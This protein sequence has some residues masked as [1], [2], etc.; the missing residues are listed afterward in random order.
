[1]SLPSFTSVYQRQYANDKTLA[2][3][4][5]Q[6]AMGGGRRGVLESMEQRLL[7]ILVY[8]KT[9]TLQVVQGDLF[10]MSQAAAN[11]WVHRLLPILQ[12]AL[13]E[14]GLMPERDGVAFAQAEQG[15]QE[16]A[17]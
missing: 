8:Q 15:K 4:P 12:K 6:R 9:Y 14:L 5:R 1:V 13:A 16:V 2:G 11:Q 7:F 10:G 3:L 17:D